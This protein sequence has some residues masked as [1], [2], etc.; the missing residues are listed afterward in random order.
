M[1]FVKQQPRQQI[2]GNILLA[3][4]QKKVLDKK[5]SFPVF[6]MDMQISWYISQNIIH[7]QHKNLLCLRRVTVLHVERTI[8]LDQ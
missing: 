7:H 2:W 4:L 8:Y 6:T 1:L 3:W 5:I